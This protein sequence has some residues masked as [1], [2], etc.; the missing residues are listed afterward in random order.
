MADDPL[1]RAE[2]ERAY[3]QVE[4]A[5]EAQVSAEPL[6]TK[7]APAAVRSFVTRTAIAVWAGSIVVLGFFVILGGDYA[8][9][10]KVFDSL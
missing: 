10:D 2:I 7:T 8:S 6:L 5:S 4:R 9:A 3:R 1:L